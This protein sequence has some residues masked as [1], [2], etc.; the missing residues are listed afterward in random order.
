[1]SIVDDVSYRERVYDIVRQI[2]RGKV[3]TYGQIAMILG[4]GYTARTVGYV[5][6][7]SGEGVPWQRVLNSRGKSSTGKLTL[8][9]DLQQGILESE[10]II[11]NKSGKC[12]LK[13]YQWYPD[14]FEPDDNE[15]TSLF[16]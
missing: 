4:E 6:H 15:Q 13:V 10:G 1:M 14:G 9:H 5:M 7:G 16:G 11:F 3:M 2:P 8:P 12:D